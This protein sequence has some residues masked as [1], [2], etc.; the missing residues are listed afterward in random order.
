[1]L[2]FY[3]AAFLQILEG[4]Q[5][6]VD[7]LVGRLASDPRHSNMSVRDDGPI[8]ARM[9]P[10]WSMAYLRLET[11][12]FDGERAVQQ[13]L[14]RDLPP[15]LRNIVLGMVSTIVGENSTRL[16]IFEFARLL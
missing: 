1:M 15:R 12:K 3:G 9:F 16:I 4:G 7:G 10:D 8:S 2:I 11:G 6:A 5:A 14:E 13:A